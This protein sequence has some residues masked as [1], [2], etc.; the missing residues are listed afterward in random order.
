VDNSLS[1]K[2]SASFPEWIQ[3]TPF[4]A[5]LTRACATGNFAPSLRG[6]TTMTREIH[7]VSVGLVF[8]F[9]GA[10]VIGVW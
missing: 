10:F 3:G 9:L 5:R 4:R 2:I 6:S 1:Q 8:L 7:I